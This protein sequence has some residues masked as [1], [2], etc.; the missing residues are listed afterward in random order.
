VV[1]GSRTE[2]RNS[3]SIDSDIRAGRTVVCNVSR[4]IIASARE[5]YANVCVVLITAP[6]GV[7][8]RRLEMRGRTTDGSV[9]DRIE[10]SSRF[11]DALRADY[12]IENT[13]TPEQG[14]GRLAEVIERRCW[15]A[16]L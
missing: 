12:V 1:G 6:V 8:A 5:R 7:L 2:I 9:L 16:Q 10:R 14:A 13:G 3:L 11:D 15:A 4:S